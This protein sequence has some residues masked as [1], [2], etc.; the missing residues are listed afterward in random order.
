MSTRLRTGPYVHALIA[1]AWQD[2]RGFLVLLP[3]H[4]NRCHRRIEAGTTIVMATAKHRYLCR[5]CRPHHVRGD[6][7]CPLCDRLRMDGPRC[8]ACSGTGYGGLD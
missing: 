3:V 2:R 4:C 5:A 8:K 6:G 1:D 7:A